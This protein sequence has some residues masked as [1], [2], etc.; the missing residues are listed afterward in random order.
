MEQLVY[1]FVSPF[2]TDRTAELIQ[3]AFQK[4]GKVI[5][6]DENRGYI[7]AKYS[8]SRV[9]SAKMEFF[10]QKAEENCR[11]RMAL[12]GDYAPTK[13]ALRRIDGWWDAVLTALWEVAPGVDFGVTL[14]KEGA[15][16]VGVQYLGSD[17][18]QTHHSATTSGTSLLGLL[19]GGAWFGSAGAIVGGMSGDQRTTSESHN[20]LSDRQIAKVIYNNG[21]LWEGVIKKGSKL[22]NEIMVNL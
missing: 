4:V 11:V 18:I 7:L 9:Q 15:Y 14:A 17:V 3:C 10:I 16:I 20:V 13:G 8:V 21:R 1:C 6:C 5:K 12:S 22:Y 2:G 19:I